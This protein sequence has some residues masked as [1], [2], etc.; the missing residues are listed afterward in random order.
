M[1]KMREHLIQAL[2]LDQF[3]V[4]KERRLPFGGAIKHSEVVDIWWWWFIFCHFCPIHKV[5][6]PN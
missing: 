3:P 1:D 6:I 2:K 5:K 4:V